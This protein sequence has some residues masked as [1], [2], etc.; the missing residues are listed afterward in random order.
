MAENKRQPA[1]K[2]APA[3]YHRGNVA[4]DLLKAASKLLET[5]QF[6]NISARRL[7]R[8]IGVTSANFYNHFPS[9]NHL[10]NAL[11]AKGFER[12]TAQNLRVLAQGLPREETLIQLAHNMV[13]FAIEHSQLFR[14]MFGQLQDVT[15]RTERADKANAS[16]AILVRAVYGADIYRPDDV[17]WSHENCL[18]AYSFFSF[19]YGLARLIS[20]GQFEFPSGTKV[21]RRKFVEDA[22][23]GFI[24]GLP[25]LPGE[26]AGDDAKRARKSS[27]PGIVISIDAARPPGRAR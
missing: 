20:M 4:E 14:I 24:R 13:E 8:E 1:A 22:T 27:G 2:A 10:M 17:A 9:F 7:C 26:T 16:F 12:R 11:A 18:H 15:E 3:P 5:E 19:T 6:E 21:E 23:R 25:P